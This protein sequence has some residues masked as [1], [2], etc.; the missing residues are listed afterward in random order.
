MVK[1]NY[2]YKNGKWSICYAY[3]D[4]RLKKLLDWNNFQ[5]YTPM[6]FSFIPLP[7]YNAQ[8]ADVSYKQFYAR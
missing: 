4:Y 8:M 5:I 7:H 3:L 6:L 1:E 2:M